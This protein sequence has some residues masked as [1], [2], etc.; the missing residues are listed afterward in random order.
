M[1][2]LFFLFSR[3]PNVFQIGCPLGKSAW[4]HQEKLTS[5]VV[6]PEVQVCVPYSFLLANQFVLDEKWAKWFRWFVFPILWMRSGSKPLNH[7]DDN[8]AQLESR[9]FFQEPLECL[10]SDISWHFHFERLCR[11]NKRNM[12][13]AHLF[14]GMCLFVE[15]AICLPSVLVQVY[16]ISACNDYY[17]NC[18]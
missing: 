17:T 14:L 16:G 11:A 4:I 12:K 5:K 7:E 1:V 3:F 15:W 6:R 9:P 8:V 2:L 10:Q 13:Y 18:W